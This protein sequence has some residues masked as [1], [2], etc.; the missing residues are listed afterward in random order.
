MTT[1]EWQGDYDS[2]FHQW[3]DGAVSGRSLLW[4]LT[5]LP[6]YRFVVRVSVRNSLRRLV[7]T[8]DISGFTRKFCGITV[9]VFSKDGPVTLRELWID[10]W[11]WRT[12]PLWRKHVLIFWMFVSPLVDFQTS[13]WKHCREEGYQEIMQT[14]SEL[15]IPPSKLPDEG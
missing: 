15:W 4:I 1:L 8:A 6:G 2:F 14:W 5:N 10:C 12:K 9:S 7:C 13:F 11:H 3:P